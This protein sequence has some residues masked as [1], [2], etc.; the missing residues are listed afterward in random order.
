MKCQ[1]CG[2]TNPDGMKFCGNCGK[3]MQLPAVEPSG[4]RNRQCVACGR[5]I[6]W[7]AIAC[8]YCGYD[9]RT[10]NKPGTE[11]FLTTG[12]VLTLL[13]GI[14][15]LLL[16]MIVLS[17]AHNLSTSS[18]AVAAITFT[19]SVLGIIGGIAA[20]MRKWFSLAV[21]GASCGIFTMAFFFAIP[22][23][24]LIA[25]SASSFKDFGM[26]PQM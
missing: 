9:Y 19:C 24:I 14:L 11:G 26:K 3:I 21:L 8:M 23:L 13:A 18:E 4:S 10:K 15:G 20:L 12:A 1:N 16:L 17:D 6:S 2:A 7:D 5:T 25:R 22:G